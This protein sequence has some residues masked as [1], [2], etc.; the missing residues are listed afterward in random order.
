VVSRHGG[1]RASATPARRRVR[2][3]W[4]RSL[5]IG[6]VAGYLAIGVTAHGAYAHPLHTTLSEL[7]IA[8][9]GSVQIVLRAF[10][11]DFSAAVTRAPSRPG[12]VPTPP[13]SAIARYLGETL[14]VTDASGRRVAL[15]VAGTRRTG[16]LV[17]VTIR[18]SAARMGVAPR[19][20]NR[21]LF[22]RWDDQVNIVQATVGSRRRT[23][24]FTRGDANVAKAI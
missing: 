11:D 16:D 5:A 8:A 3:A 21:V 18:A 7:T 24:L 4:S 22:E 15:A 23:L 6:G 10:V 13:D 14:V 9:D 20:T 2:R 19:L 12:P 1:E 17:W